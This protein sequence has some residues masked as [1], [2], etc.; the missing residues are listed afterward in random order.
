MDSHHILRGGEKA[1]RGGAT[2]TGLAL[3]SRGKLRYT[4]LAWV[5]LQVRFGGKNGNAK[6]GYFVSG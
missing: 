4:G 6:S 1:D 5:A 2:V 3:R